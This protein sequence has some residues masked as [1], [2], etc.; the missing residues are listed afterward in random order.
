MKKIKEENKKRKNLNKNIKLKNNKG[1]TLIA[2]VITIVVLIIL[3]GVAINLTLGENGIFNKAKEAKEDYKVASNEEQEQLAN[4][5][6]SIDALA[7]GS[8]LTQYA[9]YD[10]PYI[11]TGFKYKEGAWNNGYT[12]I[13]ET[14]SVGDEF[15]WVPCVLDQSKVK[16][17]RYSSNI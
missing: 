9:P 15:V 3:A 12:I 16:E 8:S 5:E 6:A 2:L 1:I 11:P 4:V 14:T 7:G 13:G 17:R 10:E